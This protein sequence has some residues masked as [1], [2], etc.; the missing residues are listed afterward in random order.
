M[1]AII[2]TYG[3]KTQFSLTLDAEN[4]D[5]KKTLE[6]LRDIIRSVRKP[7]LKL[8]HLSLDESGHKC[9]SLNFGAEVK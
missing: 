5:E 8:S 4:E 7:M 3:D 9:N 1:K 6:K 2:D